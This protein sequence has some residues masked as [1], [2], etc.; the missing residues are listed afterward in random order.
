METTPKD[1]KPKTVTITI[2]GEEFEVEGREHTA[3]ELLQLADIDPATTYLIELRGNQ[4]I[5]YR[6]KP[7]EAIR[8]HNKMRF[9][10][11]DIGSAPV[12]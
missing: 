6:D 2:D 5:P 8:L 12:A 9:V 1:K 10:S 4:Q 7:D 3:R 11:A